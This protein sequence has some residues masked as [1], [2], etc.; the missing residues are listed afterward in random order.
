MPLGSV[1]ARGQPKPVR[2]KCKTR[3]IK[4]Y[5]PAPLEL[6]VCD[7]VIRQRDGPRLYLFTLTAPNNF[8]TAKSIELDNGYYF[9]FVL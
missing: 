9:W 4:G 8:H 6:I 2:P 3:R 1:R 5:Q 7:T